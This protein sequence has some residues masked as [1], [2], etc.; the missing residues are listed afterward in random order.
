MC[1]GLHLR[2]DLKASQAKFEDGYVGGSQ[3]R[4]TQNGRFPLGLSLFEYQING[5]EKQVLKPG[6][7]THGVFVLKSLQSKLK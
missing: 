1:D 6:G 2:E 4:V 7:P 5:F 3:I